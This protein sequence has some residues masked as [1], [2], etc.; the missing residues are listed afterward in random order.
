MA[1]PHP[2]K[3]NSPVGIPCSS[4][5]VGMIIYNERAIIE[6]TIGALLAAGFD[7][8]VILDMQST[9][10]TVDYIRS[11]LGCRAQVVSFPRRS[12]IEY[13]YAEARNACAV[14]STRE[15][16]LFVDA[17]EVLISGVQDGF[18][19]L[20]GDGENPDIYGIERNNLKRDSVN[21]ADAIRVD[22]VETHNRLYKPTFRMR[23]SG[24][25]HE[26]ICLSGKSCYN[27]SGQT[28]LIFDHCSHLKT[29]VDAEQKA[30]LYA[31]MLLRGYNQ[32]DL[33]V[34]TNCWWYDS[35]VPQHIAAYSVRAQLFAKQ[36]GLK[37]EFYGALGPATRDDGRL[38]N[39]MSTLI[40]CAVTP[41]TQEEV[42]F[43][44][45]NLR[46]L[47]S[48]PCSR[49]TGTP[50][51]ALWGEWN[52]PHEGSRTLTSIIE[53]AQT[54][55]WDRFIK[56]D[57]VVIDIGGHSGDTAI[58][59]ALFA[60]DK[61]TGRKGNVVVVE[62]NPAVV[63]VLNVNLALNTHLG[64]FHS[65]MA[66]VTA[67]DVEEI[68]LAD[69]GNAQCNGGVLGDQ[70]LSA[71]LTE[72]LLSSAG[73]RYRTPGIS[74]ATLF[75]HVGNH[76]SSDPIGFIKIDCEGYDKEILRPCRELFAEHK[77]VLFVEWFNWFTPEDD[78]D[79]FSVINAIDY[80]A[81]DPTTLQ[82][83]DVSV[84]IGDLLCL[85]RETPLTS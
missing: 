40:P 77:P 65:L 57:Q 7:S 16:L 26:E 58:P 56:P 8:F 10:G 72:R 19:Q 37:P 35:H 20:K 32:P 52:H 34:G 84:R 28:A 60:Y 85:H 61:A 2:A 33:R 6:P 29:A 68:E 42:T 78:A 43:D 41:A 73:I 24:Y 23:Y 74:L 12:L 51:R 45:G 39:L 63:P 13:G 1:D 76:I 3:T 5:D 64:H 62:P 50:E 15:W 17:D 14:F 71:E 30:G 47:H 48:A 55:N 82:P 69:H 38:K 66:A 83:A 53:A 21:G 18:V 31:L 70:T 9:D 49:W 67:E 59:M 80:I 44:L 27:V 36:Q 46:A 25:I 4:I 75:S 22:S 54:W 81:Y 11:C 79:L